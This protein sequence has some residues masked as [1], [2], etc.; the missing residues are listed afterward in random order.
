[1]LFFKLYIFINKK[2]MDKEELVKKIEE[3]FSIRELAK[4]FGRSFTSVRYWIKKYDLKTDGYKKVNNWDKD[5]L[6]K[7]VNKSECK[8]DVLRNLG[9]KLNSGNFQTL[10]KYCKKYSIDVSGIEY[11]NNRGSKFL[12][13]KTN[14]EILVKNST[15]SRGHLKNRLYKYGLKERKCEMPGCGQ[16]EEW[17]G[18]K[19]SLILDHINGVNDDN[20]IENLRIVCPNCNATLK[21]HCKGKKG[22]I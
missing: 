2:Q 19:M 7:A 3:G 5:L 22:L 14:E 11:K 12:E 8:S 10:D 1:M 15:Y 17:M 21:T 6:V 9:I 18:K 13:E 20:R 16:G 4:H